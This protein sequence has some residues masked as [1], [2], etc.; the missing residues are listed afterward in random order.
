MKNTLWRGWF[1][2]W[3]VRSFG[4]KIFKQCHDVSDKQQQPKKI[5]KKIFK[6]IFLI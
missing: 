2:I 4:Y 6:T 3:I 5:D 1:G